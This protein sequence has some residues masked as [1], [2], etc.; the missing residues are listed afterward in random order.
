MRNPEPV[1]KALRCAIYTRKSSEEGLDQEFNSLDAQREACAAYILSQR[2]EG[3]TLVPE[4][5]DDG[6]YS[7]GNMERPGL[8][9]LLAD[10]RGGKVDV[11]VVYKADRLTRSLADFARI[12]DV[13]D[14]ADASFVS[15]TQSFNTTTSMG[16][17]TLNVLLS[18]AQFEREVTGER[19]RDKI[20]ASKKKGM[21]MGGT[22]PLGYNVVNRKLVINETEAETVRMI[23]RRYL[24]L[25]SVRELVHELRAQGVRTK[26]QKLATGGTRGGIAFMSGGL[27]HLLK[28]RIYLGE[29]VHRGEVHPGEHP[30]IVERALWERVQA[31][32]GE[33]TAERRH[34]TRARHPS[35]LSSIIKD[36]HG[37]PMYPSH[38]VKGARRYRYYITHPK[39]V[40]KGDPPAWRLPAHDLERLVVERLGQFLADPAALHGAVGNDDSLALQSYLVAGADAAARLK[41]ASPAEQRAILLDW[42]EGIAIGEGK[43][44]ISIRKPLA[45]ASGALLSI[46]MAKVRRGIDVRLVIPGSKASAPRDEQLV[47]LIADAMAARASLFAEPARSIE[48]AARAAGHGLARF[49]RLVRLAHLAPEIVS[50]VLK[51]HQPETLKVARLSTITRLPLCWQEQKA[52]LGFA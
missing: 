16:R 6:G 50:A 1:R 14:E 51:G 44:D 26:V 18:F 31:L 8:Q 33:R 46:P 17:L 52:L 21:W 32:M 29:I 4:F 47:M 19:I 41:I 34:G 7:G 5:Y 20:A 24:E 27:R 10:V 40:R 13:L 43:L 36:G 3:W 35:L 15:V 49:K 23:M 37:R 22:V 30:P 48:D 12:V 28:N 39:A 2:H 38:A 25:G 9:Q 45:G 11:V 42:V